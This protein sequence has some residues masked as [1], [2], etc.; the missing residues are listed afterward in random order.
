MYAPTHLQIFGID[1]QNGENV[2]ALPFGSPND[3]DQFVAAVVARIK[4]VPDLGGQAALPKPHQA[5]LLCTT[6]EPN[7]VLHLI[8][9]TGTGQHRNVAITANIQVMH[10]PGVGVATLVMGFDQFDPHLDATP[11]PPQLESR[12]MPEVS[13]V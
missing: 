11:P 5:L 6:V 7:V 4:D 2:A 8:T 1:V 13:W 3:R 9:S 10:A 12:V